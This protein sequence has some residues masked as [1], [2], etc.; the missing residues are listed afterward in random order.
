MN[1]ILIAYLLVLIFL[2]VKRDRFAN[3]SALRSA[4]ITFALIPI[5]Y[6]VFALFRAGNFRDPRDLAL[7]E[8]WANGVEWLL[9]GISMLFLTQMIAPH[10]WDNRSTPPPP[11]PATP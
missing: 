1:W 3:S 4:W 5:S 11:P 10:P 9:L 6:F 7:I 2:A 8:I